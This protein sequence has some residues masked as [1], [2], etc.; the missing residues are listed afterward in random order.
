LLAIVVWTVLIGSTIG[1]FAALSA[2]GLSGTT[3]ALIGIPVF[4]ILVYA[5]AEVARRRRFRSR[6]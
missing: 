2:L 3:S 5:L 6:D 1:F 4:V